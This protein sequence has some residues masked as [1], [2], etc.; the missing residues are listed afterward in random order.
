MSTLVQIYVRLLDEAVDVWR[1]VQ[2]KFVSGD[3]FYLVEQEYDRDIESW[4]FEPGDHVLC[5]FIRLSENGEI[6]FAAT[7]KVEFSDFD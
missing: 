6:I 4:E 5:K 2:A 7:S 1:P 3:V